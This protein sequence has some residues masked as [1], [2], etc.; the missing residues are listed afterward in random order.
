MVSN[1][2]SI[3]NLIRQ[4]ITFLLVVIVLAAST[5]F[6]FPTSRVQAASSTGVS[7][8]SLS[9]V[10]SN[11]NVGDNVRINFQIRPSTNNLPSV[12]AVVEVHNQAGG[13]VW[14]STPN[15]QNQIVNISS[16]GIQQVYFNFNLASNA[17]SGTYSI[18]A[19]IRGGN[20]GTSGWDTVY[21]AT[22][23]GS[24]GSGYS[25]PHFQVNPP[26]PTSNAS[27]EQTS[28]SVT[29]PSLSSSGGQITVTI[30]T[31]ETN[32]TVS[33]ITFS[34]SGPSLSQSSTASQVGYAS[35]TTYVSRG[36]QTTFN[37]P[38]NTTTSIRT[39]TI[40][41]SSS[42]IS[43]NPTGSATVQ[44]QSQTTA[45]PI[46]SVSATS[47]NFGSSTTS[48]T[49]SITN[50]GGGTLTWNI[51]DDQTWLGCSPSSGS[52]TTGISTIT[53]TV[54]RI[55][56]AANTYTGTITI[57]S[58]GGTK[59]ISVTMQVQLPE[60][61][62]SDEE[63]DFGTTLTSQSLS[64]ANTCAGTLTWSITD[65]QSWL[66][67][68]PSNGSTTTETDTVT[69]TIGRTGLAANKYTGKITITSNGGTQ[70]I[71]VSMQV[72]SSTTTISGQIINVTT[73]K[74]T[75]NPGD[76]VTVTFV[77]KNTGKVSA[78][79]RAVVDILP[80]N[81]TPYSTT[82]VYDSHPDQDKQLSLSIGASGTATFTWVIPQSPTPGKYIVQSSLRSW[83]ESEW[84]TVYDYQWDTSNPKTTFVIVNNSSLNSTSLT[85]ARKFAP[86]LFL[87]AND[88]EPR[89]IEIML[90][91]SILSNGLVLPKRIVH[92]KASDLALGEWNTADSSLDVENVEVLTLTGILDNT[93]A[94][95]E[96]KRILGNNPGSYPVTYYVRFKSLYGKTIIQYWLFYYYNDFYNDHEGDW[97]MIQVI[98]DGDDILK[99]NLKPVEVALTGHDHGISLTWEDVDTTGT[100]PNIYVA[101]GSHA[102]YFNNDAH[103]RTY[104][105]LVQLDDVTSTERQIIGENVSIIK[106][107]DSTPWLQYKGHWGQ[108]IMSPY[109]SGPQGPLWKSTWNKPFEWYRNIGSPLGY[110]LYVPGIDLLPYSISNA[111]E[112]GTFPEEISNHNSLARYTPAWFSYKPSGGYLGEKAAY[113]SVDTRQHLAV[114]AEA[115]DEQ[116]KGLIKEWQ[117]AHPG[118]VPEIVIVS[119]SLGGAVTAY[120]AS[121]ANQDILSAVRT[122]FTLDSPIAGTTKSRDMFA[123]PLDDFF[124]GDAGDDLLNPKVI[125]R[126]AYGTSRV[127]FAEVGNASDKMVW[128]KE[129]YT[130]SGWKKQPIDSSTGDAWPYHNAVFT[131]F[132]TSA[133]IGSVLGSIPPL[134]SNSLKRPASMPSEDIPTN[135]TV[136]TS[137]SASFVFQNTRLTGG[138]QSSFSLM[139][140][141]S[142]RSISSG[143]VEITFDPSA[144]EVSDI[145]PGNILGSDAIVGIKTI[146]N[147]N[148][149]IRFAA[150]RKG[151][152]TTTSKDPLAII[153][154]KV[155]PNVKSG[156]YNISIT[157]I[158]VTD[159]TFK[160]VTGIKTESAV[161]T[162]GSNQNDING[163]NIVDYRDLAILGAA[164]GSKKGDPAYKEAADLNGDG[165][166][167]YK[168]LA[169]LGANY[170]K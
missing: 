126:M 58:N 31:D 28:I 87:A 45:T 107:D 157:Q 118:T 154:F 159:D 151:A 131:C 161:I 129:S 95:T 30:A 100:H 61:A 111:R 43:G 119:H 14:D 4:S 70:T 54:S 73:D 121:W 91:N 138:A 86:N 136:S 33:P 83:S 68:S 141:P 69:V 106:I 51:A 145:V 53:V 81:S 164:Y 39:Y 112:R 97:E 84:D 93:G 108:I 52:T 165:I 57:T 104:Y 140:D 113:T 3:T 26:T 44:G 94:Q 41:A 120:W 88:Y 46:L 89:P 125:E 155:K 20:Y 147:V 76:I 2:R 105:Y 115:I 122:V 101:K 74:S 152:A 49:F 160:D 48:G 162:I 50:T 137:P 56:L 117:T 25:S 139:L 55:N 110:V 166:V 35:H 34:I 149:K 64:I 32:M 5:S 82:F 11:Y 12:V 72:T 132:D 8:Y 16:G 80:P 13:V 6:I 17:P 142:G 65:D 22:W 150:A 128:D 29:P 168:D 148:G 158:K 99:G 60:L 75:Y 10:N 102:N 15:G 130:S 144:F 42:Q 134:W 153:N 38:A 90:E 103:P 21:D 96:Y 109:S 77:A 167:D 79:Y 124:R 37:I 47:L 169:I 116:I 156:N 71:L 170:G 1:P 7:I 78:N 133:F 92:P 98:F 9:A 127:D 18:V 146:D 123:G 19:A 85:L 163:D 143:E 62:V 24:W 59:T 36:W 114:S 27:W 63:L 40:T 135:S 66:S 23:A 67:C